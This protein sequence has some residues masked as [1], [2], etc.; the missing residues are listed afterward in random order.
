MSATLRHDI[1]NE[2]ANAVS[3]TVAGTLEA[4]AGKP[5]T[6]W[7]GVRRGGWTRHCHTFA[8]KLPVQIGQL[9]RLCDTLAAVETTDRPWVVRKQAHLLR[10]KLL[11]SVGWP[12]GGVTQGE[13]RAFVEAVVEAPDEL[14]TWSAWADWLQER[15]GDV[16]QA[17]GALMA[18]WLA[19]KALKVKYGVPELVRDRPWQNFAD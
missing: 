14:A 17:R 10:L 11:Y 4:F 1:G 3:Q 2:L 13:E 18:G 9:W 16:Y 7:A 5:V 6:R 19:R 12:V 15:P 8:I